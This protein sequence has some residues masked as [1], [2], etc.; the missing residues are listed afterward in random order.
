VSAIAASTQT[1]VGDMV[2]GPSLLALNGRSAH[3]ATTLLDGSVWL[4]GGEAQGSGTLASTELL[5][6]GSTLVVAAGPLDSARSQH[7]AT[8]LADGRVL[9][10][11]GE[12]ATTGP[13]RTTLRSAEI[14]DPATRSSRAIASMTTP[15]IGHSA[16]RLRDGRVLM[17]GGLSPSASGG[18][19]NETAE[20]FEPAAGAFRP[21]GQMRSGGGIHSATLLAD[22]R[23]LFVAAT[24]AEL[25]DPG[26]GAFTAIGAPA[27]VHAAHT[28]TRLADGRVL[29]AGG[30]G[31][32]FEEVYDPAAGAFRPVGALATAR[33]GHSAT[34]L[35]DGRVLIAGGG[36]VADPGGPRPVAQPVL[37]TEI[38][39]PASGQFTPGPAASIARLGHSAALLPEAVWI[40]G[41]TTDK[42]GELLWLPRA[43]SASGG[44]AQTLRAVIARW[45]SFQLTSATPYEFARSWLPE[46]GVRFLYAGMQRLLGPT[47]LE[48]LTGVAPFLSG[49][50]GALPNLT[51]HTD[52]GRYN[53]DFVVAVRKE[54]ETALADPR[55]ADLARVIYDVKL[56]QQA[57][58][59]Y[60]AYHAVKTFPDRGSLID[61]Y[62]QAVAGGA[63]C[64][65]VPATQR[66]ACS[67]TAV[68]RARLASFS[69][70]V[71]RSG[72]DF[73]EAAVAPAF[74]IRRSI[75][76]T[77]D[78]FF[79][80]LMLVLQRFDQ[81]FVSAPH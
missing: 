37:S 66:M 62:Q 17:A 39:D 24:K 55:T 72:Y 77:E 41:G 61:A 53:P 18:R 71:Q 10:T 16:T 80:L 47:A 1:A 22:G 28:A 56:R 74:W 5:L 30:V 63:R 20:V 46:S 21:V 9:V 52:F 27:S 58:V 13:A 54:L 15:R 49:P 73:Y 59:Y 23:V 6:A 50:H 11:G 57:R 69:G 40:V 48:A 76:G 32:R 78:E 8:L 29:I 44:L 31:S 79:A 36:H 64:D 60:L 33:T 68:V 12:V 3:T 2:P 42:R 75:D 65:S 7:T 67:P 45:E 38:F 34:L 51:S 4:A 19:V 70:A 26:T 14:Y 81:A 43:R 25:F 35:P